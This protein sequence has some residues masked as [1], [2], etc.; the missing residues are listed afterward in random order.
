MA[1]EVW[2][3]REWQGKFGEASA[4]NQGSYLRLGRGHQWIT[5]QEGG[6]IGEALSRWQ[7]ASPVERTGLGWAP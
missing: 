2:E 1:R 5:G 7:W 6:A 3:E 4:W